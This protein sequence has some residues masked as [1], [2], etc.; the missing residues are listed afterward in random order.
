MLLYPG[1]K[2]GRTSAGKSSTKTC[3]L[4]SGTSLLQAGNGTPSGV[5]Y[6][7]GRLIPDD[8]F[9]RSNHDKRGH[10][11]DE[12]LVP[13]RMLQTAEGLPSISRFVEGLR[14]ARLD[15]E[16]NLTGWRTLFAPHK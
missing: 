1:C 9:T 12:S 10:R 4:G 5:S 11:R 13:K 7:R 2:H 16:L 3:S 14:A 15:N 6:V 8:E